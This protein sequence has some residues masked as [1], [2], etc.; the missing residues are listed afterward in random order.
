MK[1][2]KR[3]VL[4]VLLLVVIAAVVLYF[5]LNRIV[6]STIVSQSGQSLNVITTLDGANVG[7]FSGNVTLNEFAI[8]S[9]KGFSAPQMFSL[10]KVSVNVSYGELRHQPVR[11]ADITIERP[12]LVI[13]QAGGKFNIKALM[14]QMPQD[15]AGGDKPASGEPLKLIIGRLQVT[16]P[17]VVIRPGIPGLDKEIAVDIP[18]IDLTNIGSAEGNQNGLAI[19]QVTMQ[20]VN[21]MADGAAKSDKVP[22]AV[23]KLLSLDVK[24]IEEQ[25]KGEIDKQLGKITKDLGGKDAGKA[26]EGLLGGKDKSKEKK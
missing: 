21:A 3:I 2:I 11:I 8:G 24:K 17:K 26:I 25:V 18:T 1:T 9:P 4:A 14:D 15:Q 16:E 13:E 22:A 20:V 10:G 19:K 12:R 6:R 5:Q 23:Q 7:L